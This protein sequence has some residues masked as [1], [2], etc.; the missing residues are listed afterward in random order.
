MVSGGHGTS[1]RDFEEIRNS[2]DVP[3]ELLKTFGTLKGSRGR[4][5]E[6]A[7]ECPKEAL[8]VWNGPD[9][10]KKA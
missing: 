1:K 7:I 8:E 4:R 9:R 10:P 3:T 5:S 2:R 6:A